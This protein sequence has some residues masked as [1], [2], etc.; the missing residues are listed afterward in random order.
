[1]PAAGTAAGGATLGGGSSGSG[2][3]GGGGGGSLQASIAR[4]DALG[5]MRH[6][7]EMKARM[8]GG[9]GGK[10]DGGAKPDAGAACEPPAQ[11]PAESR[12]AVGGELEAASGPLKAGV[13]ESRPLISAVPVSCAQVL[14]EH[15]IQVP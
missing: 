9:G 4:A 7:V 6:L 12:P 8:V 3:A 11:S 2:G 1:M 14:P 15:R 5:V 13:F 10:P